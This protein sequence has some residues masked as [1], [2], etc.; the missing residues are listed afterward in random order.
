MKL[1]EFILPLETCLGFGVFQAV[2]KPNVTQVC[3]NFADRL[4]ERVNHIKQEY[5][6]LTVPCFEQLLEFLLVKCGRRWRH[7]VDY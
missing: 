4:R 3:R 6:F 7:G 5:F 1:F 2:V